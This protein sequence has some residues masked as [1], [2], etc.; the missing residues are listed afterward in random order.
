MAIFFQGFHLQLKRVAM[1]HNSISK[2]GQGIHHSAVLKRRRKKRRMVITLQRGSFLYY[3]CI[4]QISRP[5]LSISNRPTR[6]FTI[7][8]KTTANISTYLNTNKGKLSTAECSST[9]RRAKLFLHFVQMRP[10]FL[11]SWNSMQN[12][13]GPWGMVSK[14]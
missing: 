3:F 14:L 7:Q 5:R 2:L 12:T 9:G 11:P 10:A 8:F 1:P 4:I 6:Q 13:W